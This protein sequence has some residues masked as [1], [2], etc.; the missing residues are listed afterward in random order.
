MKHNDKFFTSEHYNRAIT[1]P[2]YQA[3]L[4]AQ[5]QGRWL[6]FDVVFFFTQ[7][8]WFLYYKMY[9]EAFVYILLLANLS[10]V[11]FI[12]DHA[13][14]LNFYYG[15]VFSTGIVMSFCNLRLFQNA[16]NRKLYAT[17]QT[18]RLQLLRVKPYDPFRFFFV[19]LGGSWLLLMTFLVL[20]PVTVHVFN[21]AA[22][23]I[24]NKTIHPK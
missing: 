24:Q 7:F 8:F 19:M 21:Q 14:G 10:A 6:K 18:P 9:A 22:I 16:L 5:R 2:P 13:A 17:R 4:Y 20:N 3:F 11:L 1:P 12:D 15:L 23:K